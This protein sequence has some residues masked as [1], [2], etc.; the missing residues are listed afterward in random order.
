MTS[1][2][3]GTVSLA[4]LREALDDFTV[5]ARLGPA[6]TA[7]AGGA[8]AR[9]PGRR[10]TRA[11][12][13]ASG[14]RRWCGLF[15]LGEAGAP[16]TTRGSRCVRSTWQRPH[17]LVEVDG[18]SVRARVEVR[19][20]ATDTDG[21]WWVVSDFGSDVRPGT[22]RARPRARHRRGVAD[23]RAGDAVRR[24]VG[25]ALDLGTGC[26]V[27]ALH[28][29]T[30]AGA[31]VATDIS[32]RALRWRRRRRSCRARRG[33]CARV[34]ARPGRRRARSTWWWRIRRSS[35][36]PASIATPAAT[37]TATAGWPATRRAPR[38]SRGI[39]ALLDAGRHGVAAGELDHPGRRRLGR[40]GRGLARRGTV[41]RVGVAARGRR[42]RA[43]TSTLWL[44]DAGETPGSRRAGASATTD[45]WTG[46]SSEGVA[47]I[48]MGLVTMWRT[49]GAVPARWCAR[50]CRRRSSSR[51]APHID[52][53]VD[54]RRWLAGHDDAT[55]LGARLRHAD[56]SR[57]QHATTSSA[58]TAGRR[59]RVAA[60]ADDGHALGGRRPT[61]RWP[62]WWRR[63]TGRLP[64][65][66]ARRRAGRDGTASRTAEVASAVAARSCAI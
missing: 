51:P 1:P 19:P 43:S 6:R 49:D 37:T 33:S 14:W 2:L 29:G 26:G 41:R 64:L 32:A 15:L 52:A 55:L 54:R 61:T 30:H 50:T 10:R 25:R 45:G 31:V 20:Y 22:A 39:P 16:S 4:L 12:L 23:A 13:A 40:P 56:G 9:R 35:S 27:Q 59:R 53:W 34:A 5:D 7:R 3:L 8:P 38:W 17:E 44:R 47:A 28:A 63:A 18:D 57:A 46:S 65:R 42:A 60:A 11:A 62:A 21:P 36:R 48:G 58:T 24:G 66:R